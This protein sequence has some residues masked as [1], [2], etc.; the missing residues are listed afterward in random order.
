MK[1]IVELDEVAVDIQHALFLCLDAMG[2]DYY[3]PEELNN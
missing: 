2:L 3:Y 1:L